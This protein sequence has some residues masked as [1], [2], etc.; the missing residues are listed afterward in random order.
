[1]LNLNRQEQALTQGQAQGR[2][3]VARAVQIDEIS[4]QPDNQAAP[5]ADSLAQPGPGQQIDPALVAQ[6]VFELM[7]ADLRV[8]RERRRPGK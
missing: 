3:V 8:E 5:P 6:K 1:M 2:R 7:R 4:P